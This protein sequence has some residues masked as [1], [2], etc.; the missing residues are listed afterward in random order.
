MPEKKKK[1]GLKITKDALKTLI[2]DAITDSNKELNQKIADIEK[3]QPDLIGGSPE[4]AAQKDVP[5]KKESELKFTVKRESRNGLPPVDEFSFVRFLN[6]QR[7]HSWAGADYEKWALDQSIQKDTPLTSGSTS[8][9]YWIGAE[10]LPAEF[11]GYYG[12]AQI[13][14]QAGCRVLPCTGTPVN[15]PKMTAG[16]TVSWL[17]ENAASTKTDATP[18]QLQLSPNLAVARTQISKTLFRTSSG[19]AETLLRQDMGTALGRKVDLGILEGA[20]TNEPTGMSNTSS[21]GTV[22]A[23]SGAITIA[24]LRDQELDL[25]TA[26]A[27]FVKPAYLMHPR[28]W[29]AICEIVKATTARDFVM[30]VDRQP[31]E[32]VGRNILGYPVYLSTQISITNGTAGNEANVFFVD[33]DDIIL[34]E[35]G[36]IEIEATDTGGDAFAEY[37]IE[38]RAVAQVDVGVRN[39]GSISL[40]SDT[41]S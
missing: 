41:T 16:V 1:E 25:Q 19:A 5:E 11:I 36:G 30:A 35:W 2:G 4:D 14:R 28:T 6:A 39:A 33:M 3:R 9:G 27:R 15:I 31:S 29:H 32:G 21:I 26:N 18:G 20:G 34:A 37:A 22:A 40:I 8:G 7:T 38:V 17:A 12:A 10:F 13:C 23:S 24:M